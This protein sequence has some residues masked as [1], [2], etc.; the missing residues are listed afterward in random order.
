MRSIYLLIII[1]LFVVSTKAQQQHINNP[2][3][4]V[5]HYSYAVTLNDENDEINAIAAITVMF[6]KKSGI[7]TFD[8]IGK[9]T[10]GKGMVATAVSENKNKLLFEQNATRIK[11]E[12][13]QPAQAG[14]L[15]TFN[16]NYSGT[17]ADGLVFSKNKFA[18]RTIFADNWPNRARNWLP[19]IDH[20]SDK[21][22]VEFSVTAPDHYKV[23]SNGILIEEST[24]ENHK[25]L[26]HWKETVE[27][28]TK[29]MVIGLADFA[30]NYPGNIDC[31]PVSSWVFP[32]DKN[33][34]FYDYEQALQI[35]PFFIKKVGNYPFKKLANVEAIT[36]F[37]GM[38]N[39]SAIFYNERTITG[40]RGY[41][42]ELIAHEIAHQWF[43]NSAT[44]TDWPHVWLSEGFATAM[45][46][47][48][49][50]NKYGKDTLQHRLQADRNIIIDFAKKR[51]TPIVDTSEAENFKALLNRNSYQKG[52]WVLHM[53]RRK[54]GD[55]LFWKS[56]K[57]YYAAYAGKNATTDDLRKVF[58]KTSGLPLQKFFKQWLYT[59]GHPVLEIKWS[60]DE[61]K[62]A[63]MLQ[64]NQLQKTTFSFP[65]QFLIYQNKKSEN[66]N[67]TFLINESITSMKISVSDK[68][69]KIVADPE[70]NLLYEGRV[71]EEK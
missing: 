57:A 70:T 15:R 17:P 48:Y 36:V 8:F 4:D 34:G 32:Q 40:K 19:C 12:L 25:K 24:Q 52:G 29:V 27:I 10:A 11:I 51:F 6:L 58:E 3:I 22:S 41:S 63:V 35:L 45:T 67:K 71:V 20:P 56:I 49:L 5:Q 60:Y 69:T 39:A 30:V 37:G 1:T 26:T 43:G 7:I 62:K 33:N 55:H 59:A 53:L 65:M 14:E 46:N 50:E 9:N 47:L 2:F 61:E 66:I 68:P 16:I 31:I 42:E 54:M 18:E 38:E 64:I 23:I 44:E 21:A 28:P 13:N